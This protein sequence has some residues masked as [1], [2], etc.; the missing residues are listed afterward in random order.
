MIRWMNG[1]IVKYDDG[2]KKVARKS[3]LDPDRT[4]FLRDYGSIIHQSQFRRQSHK[5]QVFLNAELDFPRTRLTHCIE[6]EQISRELSRYFIRNLA[7][8]LIVPVDLNRD[9]EDL[10]ATASIAH[11][12][13]QAP[14][15]HRAE[16]VLGDLMK[17]AAAPSSFEANKQNVRL[18]VGSIA[19]PEYGVSAA[20]V[21]AVMKYKDIHFNKDKDKSPGCYSFERNIVE[22]IAE[23]NGTKDI[24]HPACYIMEASDDIAYISGD[25]QDAIK[26]KIVSPDVIKRILATLSNIEGFEPL[27]NVFEK[28]SVGNTEDI[29]DILSSVLKFLISAAKRNILMFIK[30][31]G[32]TESIDSI[33]QLM[34]DYFSKNSTNMNV[35]YTNGSKS[36]ENAKKQIYRECILVSP[37]IAKNEILAGKIV[38]DLW[39]IA[40]DQLLNDRFEKS[41]LFKIMPDHVQKHIIC[42]HSNPNFADQKHQVLADYISGMTDRYAI[43]MWKSLFDPASLR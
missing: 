36:I 26:L 18:L 20:L 13:G 21:D 9:F 15:G 1:G 38:R 34:H 30:S 39:G 17:A 16:V 31:I 5:T 37:L 27:K 42:A 41:D 4:P 32:K 29:K 43:F 24:R 28:I 23:T 25:I 10:V 11:D 19:R 7:M 3:L 33:P 22:I 40:N 8:R 6:V 35:L 12:I 2:I 14:F